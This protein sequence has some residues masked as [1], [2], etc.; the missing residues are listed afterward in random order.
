MSAPATAPRVGMTL[1]QAAQCRF[2]N[3]MEQ[4]R[5]AL[6]SG[7]SADIVRVSVALHAAKAGVPKRWHAAV[8]RAF[9]ESSRPATA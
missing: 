7:S 4:Y 2:L 1:K 3:L 8:G 5:A 6:K 9:R